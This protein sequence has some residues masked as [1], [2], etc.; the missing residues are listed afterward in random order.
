MTKLIINNTELYITDSATNESDIFNCSYYVSNNS[1]SWLIAGESIEDCIEYMIENFACCDDPEDAEN[2]EEQELLESYFN[3]EEHTSFY[4]FVV[5]E[6]N[7]NENDRD[8]TDYMIDHS[9]DE[10]PIEEY[11]EV[12][13]LVENA[14][15]DEYIEH[16]NLCREFRLINE[17]DIAEIYQDY[18]EELVKDCYLNGN[19]LPSFLEID[20]EQTAKNCLV[21]GYGHSFSSYD[22]SEEY[23]GST[24]IFCVN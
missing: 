20:W 13:E 18:I 21:E 19:E 24:Y 4:K 23:I 12:L 2:A 3:V 22:H 11:I 15:C 16:P 7:Y 1:P 17:D 10:L 5:N 14:S 9:G 6:L 8:I